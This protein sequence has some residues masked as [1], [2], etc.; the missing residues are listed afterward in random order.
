MTK[1]GPSLSRICFVQ[2]IQ[3]LEER[4][5]GVP[6]LART[7]NSKGAQHAGQWMHHDRSHAEFAG[8]FAGVLGTR[9]TEDRQRVLL[10]IVPPSH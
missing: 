9:S 4:P 3:R 2:L 7:G 10:R 8:Q 6:G 5:R 1:L